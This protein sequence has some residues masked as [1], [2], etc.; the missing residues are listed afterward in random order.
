MPV[1][2]RSAMPRLSAPL[3]A[4]LLLAIPCL[5]TA[6]PSGHWEGTLELP[7]QRLAMA[8]DLAG[9]AADGWS[10]TLDLPAQ[11]LQ[12]FPLTEVTADAKSASFTMPGIPGDPTLAGTFDEGGAVLSGTLT[13]SGQTFP[14]RLSRT[15][16]AAAP[17]T[18]APPVPAETAS[19]LAG[20]W[21]GALVTPGGTARIVFHVTR[22]ADGTLAAT[23]DSPDQGQTGL[24]VSR[25]R[26]EGSEIRFE[27]DYAQAAWIGSLAADGATLEGRW[28]QAGAQLPLQLK[29]EAA[30]PAAPSEPP[31]AATP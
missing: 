6:P 29:R 19:A 14:F 26:S 22:A 3:L 11:G 10:A 5:A 21:A 2:H 15:G 4:T 18:A 8:I 23:M 28:E 31:A 27:L 13:Q 9:S 17:A 30:T 1:L 16:E 24:P 12:R 20:T 7:G 25:V